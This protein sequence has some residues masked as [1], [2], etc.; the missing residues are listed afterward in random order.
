MGPTKKNIKTSN[1]H[2]DGWERECPGAESLIFFKFLFFKS[3]FSD[4][5]KSDRRNS[6]GK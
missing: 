1:G 6:L 2:K 4:S 5:R 3:S